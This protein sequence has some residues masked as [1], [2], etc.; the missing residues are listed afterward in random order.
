MKKLPPSG[1]LDKKGSSANKA[2]CGDPYSG[3]SPLKGDL[4]ACIRGWYG[5]IVTSK[6]LRYVSVFMAA[7]S[8]ICS[9]TLQELVRHLGIE[10]DGAAWI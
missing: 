5:I 10:G 3:R 6:P 7:S 8:F 9:S 1:S 4:K 2:L